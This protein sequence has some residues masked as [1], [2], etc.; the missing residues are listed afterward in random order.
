MTGF[1]P[2]QLAIAGLS[3]TIAADNKVK[4]LNDPNPPLTVTYSG[5]APGEGTANLTGMLLLRTTATD[6]SPI[7]SYPILASGYS[8]TNYV[9][10]YVDGTLLVRPN[11]PPENAALLTAMERST[12]TLD[13]NIPPAGLVQGCRQIAGNFYDCR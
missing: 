8:S 2:G 1:T 4:F 7:G 13:A 5:L 11:Q 6:T 9:I 10:T 12:K 3:L